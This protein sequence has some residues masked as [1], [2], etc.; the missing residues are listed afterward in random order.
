[1]SAKVAYTGPTGLGVAP[2]AVRPVKKDK[3]D[4]ISSLFVNEYVPPCEE[5]V[6]EVAMVHFHV[7]KLTLDVCV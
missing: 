7:G 5:W 3:A 4:S 6:R 2:D 1:L